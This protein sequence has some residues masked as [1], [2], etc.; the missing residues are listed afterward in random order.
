MRY[1]PLSVIANSPLMPPAYAWE[2]QRFYYQMPSEGAFHACME[3]VKHTGHVAMPGLT[4]IESINAPNRFVF[5]EYP[6]W[7]EWSRF[8][9]AGAIECDNG[10]ICVMID[11]MH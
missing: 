11:G 7:E 4:V 9:R 1:W 2:I 6:T 5:T 8:E 10:Q 3:V